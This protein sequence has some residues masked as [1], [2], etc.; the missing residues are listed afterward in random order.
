MCSDVDILDNVSGHLPWIAQ[1]RPRASDDVV[2]D[3][4]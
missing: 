1:A 2:L 3:F 4:C